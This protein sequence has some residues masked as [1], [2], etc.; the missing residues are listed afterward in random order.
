MTGHGPRQHAICILGMHRS[1]TSVV[2]KAVGVLGAYLGGG[3]ELLPAAPDNPEGFWERRD[4][5]ALGE[6]LLAALGTTWDTVAPLPE[7]W[8][9]SPAVGP[10]REELAA[11]IG[12]VFA[13][14]P[15][16]AWKDPRTCLLLPLWKEVLRGAGVD[17]GV[18]FTVRNPLDVA[19]SLHKRDGLP[20]ARGLGVWFN[21][22]LSAIRA[23]GELPVAF[24]SYDRFLE[25]PRRELV[26]CASALGLPWPVPASAVEASLASLARPELRHSASDSEELI[27]AG[28]VAPVR[29]LYG[30]LERLAAGASLADPEV[31]AP[32]ER[33]GAEHIAYAALFRDELAAAAEMRIVLPATEARLRECLLRQE[34]LELIERSWSWRATVPL[35]RLW[36]ALRRS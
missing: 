27:A 21:Y 36:D 5:C 23:V 6:R 10:L 20:L 19:R 1:G 24:V 18:L 22:N 12:G 34:R 29:E 3:E 28:A 13:G 9:E 14:R 33:L 15:L 35:R 30:L 25:G 26:R 32:L 8:L 17:L 11:L 16:W 7:A 31:A 4:L 2:A